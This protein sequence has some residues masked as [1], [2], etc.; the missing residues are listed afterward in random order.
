MVE[1]KLRLSLTVQGAGLLSSQECEQNP[2]SYNKHKLIITHTSGKGKHKKIVRDYIAFKTRKNKT[3]KQ[4]INLTEDAYNYM[5]NTPPSAKF[6]KDWKKMSEDERLRT[7]L[8]LIAHDRR[9]LSYS[10]EI[11]DD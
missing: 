9:A 11:I 1:T 6:F 3:V 8:D 2:G 4:C 7:H 10:Y 5:L